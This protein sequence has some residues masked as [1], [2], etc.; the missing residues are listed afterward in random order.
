MARPSRKHS[1]R[2]LTSLSFVF[3]LFIALIA[4]CPPAVSAEDKKAEY[5]TVIGIGTP[6]LLFLSSLFP[7]LIWFI[8]RLGN[9]VRSVRRA[10]I[11]TLLTF[12]PPLLYSYSCVAYVSLFQ[13]CGYAHSLTAFPLLLVCNAVA[14]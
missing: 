10:L 7:S 14:V 2:L 3:F 13:T 12:F 6:F 8:L 9:N 1:S 4:F 5:G 11:L